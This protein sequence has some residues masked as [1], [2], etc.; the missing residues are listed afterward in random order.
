MEFA[1]WSLRLLPAFMHPMRLAGEGFG[2]PNVRLTLLQD[3]VEDSSNVQHFVMRMPF[4]ESMCKNLCT[5]SEL[6]CIALHALQA[7]V[8]T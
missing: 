7:E 3:Y 5:V 2:R 6:I 8:S 4:P 1:L